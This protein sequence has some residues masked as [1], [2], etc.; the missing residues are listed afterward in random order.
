M[1]YYG[2][3]RGQIFRCICFQ[4]ALSFLADFVFWVIAILF[5]K[6]INQFSCYYHGTVQK[7]HF[8]RVETVKIKSP[9]LKKDYDFLHEIHV[10]KRKE[11]LQ[12]LL[13]KFSWVGL[14]NLQDNLLDQLTGPVD[15]SLWS[16]S[17]WNQ[18]TFWALV[19]L[20]PHHITS[21]KKL[22]KN[23]PLDKWEFSFG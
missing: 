17:K 16:V 20:F 15:F 19:K 10:R 11:T 18:L 14:P 23:G 5:Q 13:M 9:C 12:N 1:Q 8:Q 7:L 21:I 6:N 4:I 3:L 2:I 22:E